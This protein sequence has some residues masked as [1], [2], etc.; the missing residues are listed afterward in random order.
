MSSQKNVNGKAPQ[1]P[2]A[3]AFWDPKSNEIFIRLCVEQVKQGN[4]P[5][6]HLNKVGWDSVIKMFESATGKIYSRI[7]LKNRWDVL[8]REWGLWN[9]LLR[10]ASG[11]G[12]DPATGVITASDEWWNNKLQRYPDAAK[13]REKPLQ[14][15]EELDTLFN[16][17]AATGE[18][19]YT[20][21]SG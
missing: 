15:A 12:K 16:D 6:T 13:F 4:R 17:V 11:L 8:K 18:F 14:F 7:Q 9:S 2:V 3:K 5:G 20:P 10:G 21:S 1:V 19:A